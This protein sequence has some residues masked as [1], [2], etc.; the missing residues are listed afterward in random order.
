MTAL[1]QAISDVSVAEA[2]LTADTTTEANI[3]VAIA[4]ASSPLAAAKE[5]VAADVTAFNSKLDALISAA[6]ASKIPVV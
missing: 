2:T 5:A 3:E 6:T 4:A 1:D